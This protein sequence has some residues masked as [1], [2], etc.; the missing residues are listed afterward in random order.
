MQELGDTHG[1]D[2]FIPARPDTH[3][4]WHW[5]YVTGGLNRGY[6]IRDLW[7]EMEL[8]GVQPT[9]TSCILALYHSMKARR[10]N[11]AA[12]YFDQLRMGGNQPTVSAS[13]APCTIPTRPFLPSGC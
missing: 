9:E 4:F 13:P 6:K 3:R 8:N 11:D 2:Q 1:W 5:G 7:E 10:L 12:F